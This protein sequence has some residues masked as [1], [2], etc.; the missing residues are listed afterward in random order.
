MTDVV[1][2]VV[3][4][5]I[6]ILFFLFYL[7]FPFS[8]YLFLSAESR[9]H[10][11]KDFWCPH[12]GECTYESHRCDG[13]IDCRDNS[14]EKNCGR[15]S[16]VIPGTNLVFSSTVRVEFFLPQEK[17]TNGYVVN[18]PVIVTVRTILHIFDKEYILRYILVVANHKKYNILI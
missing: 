8:C 1:S 3:F 15:Y 5:I 13:V 14:D 12:S 9:C 11:Y 17:L 7:F 2:I 6:V 16:H 10:S 4:F 18:W